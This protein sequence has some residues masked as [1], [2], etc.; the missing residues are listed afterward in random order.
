MTK[1]KLNALTRE[2]GGGGRERE[3][4]REREREREREKEEWKREIFHSKES[5]LHKMICRNCKNVYLYSY[6]NIHTD[7]CVLVQ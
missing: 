4:E 2:R 6:I 3:I 5:Q 1:N 7:A